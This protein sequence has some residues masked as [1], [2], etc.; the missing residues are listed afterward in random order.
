MMLIFFERY[1]YFFDIEIYFILENVVEYW[2]L[3]FRDDL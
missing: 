1:K 2:E 3:Y